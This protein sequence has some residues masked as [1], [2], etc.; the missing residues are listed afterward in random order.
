MKLRRKREDPAAATRGKKN[1]HSG[2]FSFFANRRM[3]IHDVRPPPAGS[4]FDYITFPNGVPLVQ[5]V[6]A[7]GQQQPHS[8]PVMDGGPA[9]VT[10]FKVIIRENGGNRLK[11]SRPVSSSV[12]NIN[13]DYRHGNIVGD[14]RQQHQQQQQQP[15]SFHQDVRQLNQNV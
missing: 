8:M 9:A 3:E 4:D 11:S 13:G 2:D 7:V 5:Q 15:H 14:F 12:M 10:P 6:Y 1:R